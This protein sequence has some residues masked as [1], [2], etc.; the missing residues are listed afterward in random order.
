MHSNFETLAFTAGSHTLSGTHTG[1]TSSS[2]AV[3]A[4]LDL[5][6]GSSLSGDLTN[7]GVFEVA[8]SATGATTVTGDLTLDTSGTLSLDTAGM[9]NA[10]DLLTVSGDVSLGGTLA[11]RQSTI[12]PG[13]VTL[14]DGGTSLTGDFSST[15]G[16]KV[17]VLLSQSLV[18]D[19]GAFDLQLVTVAVTLDPDDQTHTG[20]VVLGGGTLMAGGTL[21]CIAVD[22]AT[23][24]TGNVLTHV[25][26]V[27]INVGS[28]DIPTTLSPASGDAIRALVSFDG[29][30]GITIDASN[31]T[32][33]GADNGIFAY[34]AGTGAISITAASVT[35][36]TGDGISAQLINAA[37]TG[38]ISITASGAVSG[39]ASGIFAYSARISIGHRNG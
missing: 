17:G 21:N 28:A 19:P 24:I 1:L 33:T 32:L 11:L 35:G 22:T 13:T 6:D 38:D 27:T 36:T 7:S 23:P 9:G 30:V 37:T 5:A 39:G 14:I 31:G 26:G 10:N 29:T 20:C 25:D 18:Q 3:G 12:L 8:G 16:L 15:T 2:I 34:S 4:M